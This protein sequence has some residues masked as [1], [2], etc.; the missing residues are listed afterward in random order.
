MNANPKPAGAIAAIS[1]SLFE[2]IARFG[3]LIAEES[4]AAGFSLAWLFGFVIIAVLLLMTG[5][6]ALLA[7]LALVLVQ[8]GIMGWVAVLGLVALISFAGVAIVLAVI[9]RW[10]QRP[11]FPGAR[12]QLLGRNDEAEGVIEASS[13]PG[14]AEQHVVE[15]QTAFI[16][17]CHL[18]QARLQHRVESP[19]LLGSVFLGAISV[20][21]LTGKHDKPRGLLWR[22]GLM[23][24]Q[25]ALPIWLSRQMVASPSGK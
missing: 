6:I 4:K 24:L 20:G 21:Y 2:L 9:A 8:N 25:A 7:C 15:A 14:F 18:A 1:D 10:S 3:F 13:P 11:L 16:D 22:G 23:A 19:I 5:V 17:E 12:R